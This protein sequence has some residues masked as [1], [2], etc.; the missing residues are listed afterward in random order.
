MT[1][2]DADQKGVLDLFQRAA[3]KPDVVAQVGIAL[4]AA[5]AGAMAAGAVVA[6][7]GLS[8]G[9]GVGLKRR[10]GLDLLE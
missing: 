10:I 6:E 4:G 9:Q 1:R 7:D 3:P 5:A 2:A 8:D